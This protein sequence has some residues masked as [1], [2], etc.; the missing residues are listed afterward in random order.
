MVWACC[1]CSY[2]IKTGDNFKCF[3]KNIIYTLGDIIIDINKI[4]IDIQI[5]VYI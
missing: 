2:K 3:L 5:K 1:A 4:I